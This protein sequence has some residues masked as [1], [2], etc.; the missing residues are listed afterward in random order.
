M[1]EFKFKDTPQ[2]KILEAIQKL[3]RPVLGHNFRAFN[4]R[5]NYE[6]YRNALKMFE[7]YGVPEEGRINFDE[8]DIE[9]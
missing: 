4:Q 5:I 1:N 8:Y 6:H 3:K 2:Y 9:G 7:N